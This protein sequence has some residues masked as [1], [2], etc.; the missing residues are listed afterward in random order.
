MTF[1][2]DQNFSEKLARLI[3][4]FDQTNRIVPLVDRFDR[5][6]PDLVWLKALAEDDP[7]PFVVSGDA[8][9]LTRP[10]ERAALKESGLTYFLL[11]QAWT[12]APWD[13]QAWRIIRVWPKII[14]EARQNR[15]QSIFEISFANA[16]V[17][18]RQNL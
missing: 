1:F 6:T 7:K 14:E 17:S 11:A 2:T 5:G 9:I 8:R 3:A 18:R 10:T 15:R 4:V 16:K 13:D 12:T